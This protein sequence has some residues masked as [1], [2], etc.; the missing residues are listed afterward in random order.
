LHAGAGGSRVTGKNESCG[1]N[2]LEN[3]IVIGLP[4]THSASNET[5][6]FAVKYRGPKGE[7]GYFLTHQPK[8]FDWRNATRA[9][10]PGRR[11]RPMCSSSPV[12]A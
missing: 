12:K 9:R 5:N 10:T 1:A 7:V 3:G 2:G 11:F 4:I 6:P 8:S